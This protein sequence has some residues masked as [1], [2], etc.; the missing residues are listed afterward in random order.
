MIKIKKFTFNYFS[1]NTYLL[2]D[3]TGEAVLIDSGCL[4]PAE[5]QQL[6]LFITQNKLT[7]V[8]LLCT[9]LHVDHIFGNAFIHKTYD[10]KPEA[11]HFEEEQLPASEEQARAFGMQLP[12]MAVPVGTYLEPGDIVSFG[13]SSLKCLF[14][15]GHSPGSLAFYSEPDGFVIAGDALFRGSIGRTDLWGG[16][17]E[18]L[19]S[20][21]QEQLLTLPDRTVVYPG[22]GPETTIGEEKKNNPYLY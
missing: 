16:S 6:Q 2:Y 12:V 4:F 15:P 3:E 7:P 11:H 17:T 22:H 1:E 19:I 21:I 18:T 9:H 20:S 8:H 5:E 10:L 14:V 13:N